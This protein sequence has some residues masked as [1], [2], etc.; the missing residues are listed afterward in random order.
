MI[1]GQGLWAP[2]TWNDAVW[3]FEILSDDS[4]GAWLLGRGNC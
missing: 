3:R 4:F 2:P 1:Q